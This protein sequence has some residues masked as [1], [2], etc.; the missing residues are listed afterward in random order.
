VLVK[1]AA[2]FEKNVV[3]LTDNPDSLPVV[4][5]ART[6]HQLLNGIITP[7]GLHFNVNHGGVPD[8]DPSKHRLV[9]HGMVKRPLVFRSRCCATR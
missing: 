1:T 5:H 4:S 7:N 2:P 9:I 3:R 8:I 6:S